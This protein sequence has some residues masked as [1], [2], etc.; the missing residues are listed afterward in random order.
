M[1]GTVKKEEALFQEH[2]W[3]D[4]LFFFFTLWELQNGSSFFHSEFQ[5]GVVGYFFLDHCL[6]TKGCD[7]PKCN[8]KKIL[9][10]AHHGD[11]NPPPPPQKKMEGEASAMCC[12]KVVK[13]TRDFIK[14]QIWGLGIYLTLLTAT[15]CVFSVIWGGGGG[16]DKSKLFLFF[17]CGNCLRPK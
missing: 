11:N 10:F 12:I 3:D 6:C 16:R 9:I 2:H 13:N 7:R 5:F 15:F 1:L 8:V 4:Q 14:G 17:L